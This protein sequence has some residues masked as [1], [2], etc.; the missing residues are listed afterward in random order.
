MELAPS[1]T[2]VKLN[3]DLGVWQ[4]R[5]SSLTTSYGR[6]LIDKEINEITWALKKFQ[7]SVPGNQGCSF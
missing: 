4:K 3:H 6:H 5:R 7:E 1:E 2:L